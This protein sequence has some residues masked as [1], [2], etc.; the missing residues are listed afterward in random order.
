MNKSNKDDIIQ[1]VNDIKDAFQKDEQC[2]NKLS[3]CA[4]YSM[5]YNKSRKMDGAY[6]QLKYFVMN[7]NELS[8]ASGD[9]IENEA[10]FITGSGPKG[11]LCSLTA[12]QRLQKDTSIQHN[13]SR[14]KLAVAFNPFF[15]NK[16]EYNDEILRL[17]QKVDTGI[18]SKVYLQFGTDLE[19]LS[20]ALRML[21][22]LQS[23]NRFT[24]CGSIFLPTKKLIAQQKF[25]PW[26]GVYLNDEF[27]SS[28]TGARKIVLQMM[29]LYE[30]CSAEILI[31]APGVQSEKD[32]GILESL[33]KERDAL[34]LD[35]N[36][37]NSGETAH[38][39][40]EDKTKR[41]KISSEQTTSSEMQQ[42][43]K[44]EYTTSFPPSHL[45]SKV[46]NEAAIVLFHSHDLRLHDNVALQMA[47]HHK[48]IVPVF[49]WS[50][51]EQGPFGVRGC[52]EV[53]VKDA[54]FN[55]DKKLKQYDLMLICR[56][57]DDTSCM[58]HDISTECKA[59]AV[60]FNKE[61]HQ[62]LELERISIEM[63]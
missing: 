25:R 35:S 20:G 57:G 56:E 27:L 52:L 41:R 53:V 55:L 8:N 1:S 23:S 19:R 12:L 43:S 26:N 50:K 36:S 60:Y 14:L 11:K 33:L 5:K 62:S 15:P 39:N 63:Y 40:R 18:V 2:K 49:L 61:Q 44:A 51:K 17:K 45:S 46:L 30:E 16:Q 21:T 10:L 42:Q 22:E 29:R 6:L 34:V 4:H 38:N 31:E 7:M 58:L 54:L 59:S 3:I 47:S 28:E 32:L 37:N 24:I 13:K 9:N 48:Y